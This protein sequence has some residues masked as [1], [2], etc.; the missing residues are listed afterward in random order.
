MKKGFTLIELLV[1]IVIMG[2]L[3]SLAV[4][5]FLSAQNKARDQQRKT[6][7]RNGQQILLG[8]QTTGGNVDYRMGG[9]DVGEVVDGLIDAFKEQGYD[10]PIPQN[11]IGYYLFLNTTD[12]VNDPAEQFV[13]FSCQQDKLGSTGE[14]VEDMSFIS[15]NADIVDAITEA[16]IRT[17]CD[18]DPSDPV[19]NSGWS[20]IDLS[21]KALCS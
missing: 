4:I 11:G 19:V 7:V 21:D 20:C 12:L 14:E 5:P 2:L 1:V 16:N 15:G 3:A 13:I 6:F 9:E 10:L 8:S 18:K 17:A